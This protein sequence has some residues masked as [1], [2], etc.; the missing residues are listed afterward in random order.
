MVPAK[1]KPGEVADLVGVS[2]DTVRRWCD[3]GKLETTRSEGGHRLIDGADLARY[4]LDQEDAFVPDSL[5]AQSAR[6]RLTGVV[7]KVERDTLVAIVHVQVGRHRIVSMMTREAAD[8]L[9]LQ[10]GD[11]AVAAVKSTNVV[12]EVPKP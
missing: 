4:L 11:L 1:Y 2:V 6:N 12:I 8:E 9:E 3:E 10:P 5:F 7:T